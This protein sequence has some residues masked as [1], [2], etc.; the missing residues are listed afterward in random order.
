MDDPLPPLLQL[1][2]NE[3]SS[4]RTYTALTRAGVVSP[5]F[6]PSPA[7]IAEGISILETVRDVPI[8][9]GRCIRHWYAEYGESYCQGPLVK[10]AWQTVEET[11]LPQLLNDSSPTELS[12]LCEES[13][14]CTSEPPRWPLSPADGALVQA[15]STNGVRW[16]CIGLYFALSGVELAPLVEDPEGVCFAVE[17][18]GPTRKRAMERTLEASLQCYRICE[19]MGQINDLT[20][21]LLLVASMMSTWCYGDDSY[22]AFRLMGDLS[23]VIGALGFHRATQDGPQPPFY[24]QELRKRA[25]VSA[26]EYDKGQATF[27]GRPPRLNRNYLGLGLPL[28]LPDRYLIGTP[29]DFAIAAATLDKDGWR[30][31]GSVTSITRVRATHLLERVREE[32]LEL[33][34]GSQTTDIDTR[35]QYVEN[36]WSTPHV[37]IG[38]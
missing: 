6:N 13:F 7:L 2:T 12:R 3:T 31:D 22:L 5:T 16:E 25:M 24:L 29:E 36:P 37:I 14:K 28:D 21:W 9:L 10:A 1:P 18:W 19:Q 27:V 15:L 20:M 35:A 26:H 38:Y 32:A 30:T 23:S 8:A 4:K 33:S 17:K 11:L 34:L